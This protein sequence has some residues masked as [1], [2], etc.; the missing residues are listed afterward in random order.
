MDM[1]VG[2]PSADDYNKYIVISNPIRNDATMEEASSLGDIQQTVAN[3]TVASQAAKAAQIASP[4]LTD[5]RKT[6]VSKNSVSLV[7][8]MISFLDANQTFWHDMSLTL[9]DM[10]QMSIDLKSKIDASK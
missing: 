9:Y 1:N 6:Y 7:Q 2:S 5:F 10:T 3:F 8:N 4:I